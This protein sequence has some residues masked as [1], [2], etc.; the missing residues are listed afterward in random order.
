MA[1]Q[2]SKGVFF[3]VDDGT[4]ADRIVAVRSNG[5]LVGNVRV[6]GMSTGNAEALTAGACGDRAGR[7]FY[8]GDIGDNDRERDHISVYRID[9]PAVAPLPTAPVA[10]DRWD[11]TYPDGPRNAESMVVDGKGSVIVITKS[12]ADGTT[13]TVPPHRIYR[14]EPGGGELRLVASFSPPEP[15]RRVQSMFTGNVITDAAFTPGR[16]LLLTYDQVIEY[17]APTKNADP[18]GFSSWPHHELPDPPMIQTEGI[19]GDMTGCGYEVTSEEGPGGTQ[20]G[21]AAVTC[22]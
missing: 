10:A 9:E 5:S 6:Q 7:C 4:G 18:A 21:L 3:V 16:M 14:G 1:S 17:L 20:A 8:V 12:A 15:A 22:R 19:A 13:G 2:K 11:F